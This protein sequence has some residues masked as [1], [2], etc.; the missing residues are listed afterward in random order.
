MK[1]TTNPQHKQVTKM[2]RQDVQKQS[3]PE[4]VQHQINQIFDTHLR[5]LM[6][7]WS[8][9]YEMDDVLE[10]NIEVVDSAKAVK[11]YAELPGMNSEDIVVDIST[12]GYMT[13]S[14]E[15]KHEAQDE[16]N[17]YYFS[18]RSYGMV[19]RTVPLP[20]DIDTNKVTA[21]FEKG[22]L[23]INIPKLPVA[24]EKVKRVAVKSKEK[25]GA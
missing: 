12:D 14:G 4:H 23:K 17:G 15:K 24:Q 22:V 5:H 25:K 11:V 20:T 16:G 18:E 6:T 10:P 19:A 7:P 21:D 1:K 3:N 9:E 8:S 13:I 2:N